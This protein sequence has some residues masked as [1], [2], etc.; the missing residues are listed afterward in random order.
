MKIRGGVWNLE[1]TFHYVFIN[2][3]EHEPQ[4][5]ESWNLPRDFLG[6]RIPTRIHESGAEFYQVMSHDDALVVA[7]CITATYPNVHVFTWDTDHP[8]QCN[9]RVEYR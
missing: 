9:I 3:G 7:G 2:W 4:P 1:M 8:I 5:M 6:T